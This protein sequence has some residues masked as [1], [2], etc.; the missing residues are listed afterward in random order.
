MFLRINVP[1]PFTVEKIPEWHCAVFTAIMSSI[2]LHFTHNTAHSPS[3][4][5]LLEVRPQRSAKDASRPDQVFY[6]QSSPLPTMP[7]SKR[8]TMLSTQQKEMGLAEGRRVPSEQGDRGEQAS[9]CPTA[10]V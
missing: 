4:Q 6:K 8:T 9:R 3:N 5:T 2:L 1:F 7:K 10:E